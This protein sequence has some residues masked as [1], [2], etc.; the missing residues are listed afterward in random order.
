[1]AVF[2]EVGREELNRLLNQYD[3]GEAQ[4]F[5]GISSGIE[6]SNFYLDTDKG[7]IRTYRI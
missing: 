2:T 6:N 7:Q 4:R 1:M 3:I 5:E